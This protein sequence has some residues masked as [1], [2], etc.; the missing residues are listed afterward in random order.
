M[1]L[2][3]PTN[4]LQ[5]PALIRL[6]QM[7]LYAYHGVLPQERVVGAWYTLDATLTIMLDEVALLQDDLSGTINYAEAMAVLQD[8]MAKPVQLLERASFAMACA[9]LARFERVEAVGLTLR[10]DTPPMGGNTLGASVTMHVSREQYDRL[11]Q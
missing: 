5:Q 3:M 7:R 4:Q 11:S 1:M 10:K 2:K 6:E 9:L 8:V